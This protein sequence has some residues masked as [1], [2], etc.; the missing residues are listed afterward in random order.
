MAE[1]YRAKKAAELIE[2][3][4]LQNVA[5]NL[6]QG[7]T[8]PA[9]LTGSNPIENIKKT[10]IPSDII[11][12]DPEIRNKDMFARLDERMGLPKDV[13]DDVTEGGKLKNAKLLESMIP[14]KTNGFASRLANEVSDDISKV[15]KATTEEGGFLKNLKGNKGFGRV[16]P[17]LGMGAAGLAALSIGSKAFA[18]DFGGAGLEAAD[19]ATD[20]VPGVGTAKMALRPSELGNAE[21]PEDEM[22][23]RNVYNS[24]VRRSKGMDPVNN[25]SNEMPQLAPEDRVKYEDLKRQFSGLT[26]RMKPR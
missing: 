7:R 16:L 12:I 1:D 18:G 19:L 9:T 26:D 10:T 25:P 4:R 14:P 6:E 22:E 21:L 24:Q 15:G 8:G 17:A 20:Y 23:A 11:N 3:K 13:I 2:K 5:R